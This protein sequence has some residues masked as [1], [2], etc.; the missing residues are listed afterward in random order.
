MSGDSQI[1]SRSIKNA[2]DRFGDK[3]VRDVIYRGDSLKLISQV[4]SKSIDLIFSSPPYCMGKEY[5]SSRSIEDFIE[6]HRLLIPELVRTLKLG[7]SICWQVGYHVKNN[8]TT[9]LDF[10]AHQIFAGEKDV[11]LR[12]RIIWTFE[13]GLHA[14]KRFSGRHEVILWYTKGDVKF[15]LDSVRVPQKYPGKKSYRGPNKGEFSGNPLGKNPGDVWNVPNV[16]GNHIEKTEHP[17]QFPVALPLAF[18][19]AVCP[20]RGVVFDPFM[21]VGS[22]GVAAAIAKRRFLGSEVVPEYAR[23]AA[24]RIREARDDRAAFRP[25]WQPIHKPKP[26]DSVARRPE[27][28][29]G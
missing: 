20:P 18:V 1:V 8:V 22:T 5:E 17:C 13:H 2:L 28:F 7:G 3:K 4:P 21:G 6:S 26:T 19:K 23:I 11:V 25:F 9:P 15:D 24:K 29:R 14:S 12:N 10:L 27:H 16:K